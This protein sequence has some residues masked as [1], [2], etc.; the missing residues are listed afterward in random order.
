MMATQYAVQSHPFYGDTEAHAQHF[1]SVQADE[2]PELY[3]PAV[4][5]ME[6][7]KDFRISDS[8]WQALHINAVPA[9]LY[10]S[11]RLGKPAA[12]YPSTAGVT[13][14]VLESEPW[15]V[16]IRNN[17]SLADISPDT[18]GL[19]VNS[20]GGHRRYFRLSPKHGSELIALF[21]EQAINNFFF[22]AEDIVQ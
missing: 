6:E 20:V 9:F 2:L 11:S 16:I 5:Y 12:F 8:E 3:D 21:H 17:P 22:S 14:A 15:A 7:L 4:P 13:E 1:S 10:F 18:G 19:F